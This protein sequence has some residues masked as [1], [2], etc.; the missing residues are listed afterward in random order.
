[1]RQPPDRCS[2]AL[3]D[4]T[5]LPLR[6]DMRALAR[7]IL[8]IDMSRQ[9]LAALDDAVV[10]RRRWQA[11]IDAFYLWS[12]APD[13][14]AHTPERVLRELEAFSDGGGAWEALDRLG[15]LEQAGILTIRGYLTPCREGHTIAML[16]GEHG[17]DLVL[18][19][20][21]HTLLA[22]E[23]FELHRAGSGIVPRPQE[24]TRP[25]VTIPRDAA[26]SARA[27]RT[28]TPWSLQNRS[29]VT[30]R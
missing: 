15:A 5:R 27:T 16:A 1:M 28:P 8:P 4:G 9:T 11:T 10:L 22:H 12:G 17:Y 20:T 2:T 3:R 24:P 18:L 7:V 29:R 21:R 6:A 30:E 23:T 13:V 25:L 26:A 19:G 14:P